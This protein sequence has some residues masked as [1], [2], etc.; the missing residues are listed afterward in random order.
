MS[1]L[2]KPKYIETESGREKLC[3]QCGDYWP[4]DDEFW[5]SRN[6]KLPDGKI[7]MR[8]VSACKS[9]YDIRY[10][11]GRI[12]GKNNIRSKHERVAA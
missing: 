12:K 9:C 8:Y 2:K 6:V 11:P 7:S 4:L 3:I 5:F 1:D 10:R